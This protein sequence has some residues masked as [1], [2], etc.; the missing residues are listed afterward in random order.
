MKC[1]RVVAAIGVLLHLVMAEHAS[2]EDSKMTLAV[3]AI[4]TSSEDG[5]GNAASPVPPPPPINLLS[6]RETKLTA[7]ERQAVDIA[8]DWKNLPF[9]AGRGENGQVLFRFGAT[10]PTVVC[11][12]LYVCAIALEPGEVVNALNIGDAVRWIIT[13]AASGSGPMQTTMVIIKVTDTDLT[14]NLVIS[15]D[16]RTYVIKLVSRKSDW[17]PLV[18]F[19]YPEDEAIE[20]ANATARQEKIRTAT[21]LPQTGQNLADLDF[22]FELTGDAPSW[23]PIRVYSDGVKTYIQFPKAMQHLDAPALVALGKSRGL[24][25][26]TAMQLVNY[27]SSGDRYVVDTVLDHAALISGVGQA[28]VKVEISHTAEQAQ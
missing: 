5:T 6:G 4:D 27:R 18:S 2:A 26:G 17:M 11:A 13:P 19:S 15:T 10:L 24:F 12:P 9:Q 16:R 22:R 3:P 25:S 23:K 21:V 7:R 28:Q 8:D 20:W 1:T 14:T